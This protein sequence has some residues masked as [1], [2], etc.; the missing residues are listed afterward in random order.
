MSAT[1]TRD[2]IARLLFAV[3]VVLGAPALGVAQTGYWQYVKTDSY[4]APYSSR[5]AYPDTHSGVEGQFSVVYSEPSLNPPPTLGTTFY[6]SRPLAILIPGTA[7]YW[8]VAATVDK[9]I[10]GR[11]LGLIFTAE[12]YPYQLVSNLATMGRTEGGSSE[13]THPHSCGAFRQVAGHPPPPSPKWCPP[14]RSR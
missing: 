6:W 11:F 12:M 8:P 9:N 7:F 14:Y 13:A 10:S 3:L 5:S 1:I 4:I 2:R